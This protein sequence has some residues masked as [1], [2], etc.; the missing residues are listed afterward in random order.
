MTGHEARDDEREALTDLIAGERDKYPR[1]ADD[2]DSEDLAD[3]ILA[4]GYRKHP[5]PEAGVSFDPPYRI[6]YIDGGDAVLLP[7]RVI[8]CAG[9]VRSLVLTADRAGEMRDA[10]ENALRVAGG[11]RKESGHR[12]S[13]VTRV[14]EEVDRG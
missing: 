4:A 6:E 7:F 11:K 5:E 1:R 8:D 10:I 9:N 12:E 13:K 3:V 14:R 2:M